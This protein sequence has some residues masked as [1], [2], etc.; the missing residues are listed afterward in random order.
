MTFKQYS[1]DT[2]GNVATMFGISL[3]VFIAAIG[4]AIDYARLISTNSKLQ[5]LSD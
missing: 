2:K 4:S 5:S 3:L 1:N